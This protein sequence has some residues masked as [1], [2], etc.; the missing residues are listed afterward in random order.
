MKVKDLIQFLARADENTEAN[1]I[2]IGKYGVKDEYD[3][4][5][6]T[7]TSGADGACESVTIGCK[8]AKRKGDDA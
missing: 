6:C 8:D 2:Y 7:I 5:A 3:I 1:V 4:T